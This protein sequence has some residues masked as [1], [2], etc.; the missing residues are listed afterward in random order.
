VNPPALKGAPPWSQ[1]A[2]IGAPRIAL[3]GSQLAFGSNDA[4]VRLAFQRLGKSLEEVG[5]S[6]DHVA[7]VHFYPLSGRVADLIGRIAPEFFDRGS[8]PAGTMLP[9]EGLPSLDAA[10]GVDV[11]AALPEK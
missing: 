8:P 1:I 5:A 10:F 9:F 4:D 7:F 11:I 6:L 3:S 2:L